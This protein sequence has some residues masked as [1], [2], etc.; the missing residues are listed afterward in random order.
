MIKFFGSLI[1]IISAV[2]CGLNKV[3]IE[4]LKFREIAAF[5][6]MIKYVSDNIEHY[7]KPLPEIF[8]DMNDEYLEK[9]GLLQEIRLNG[10]NNAISTYKFKLDDTEQ[11]IVKSF[12]ERIGTGYK[13]DELSLCRFTYGKLCESEVRMQQ[14]I[15]NTEKMYLTI[16]LLLALSVILILI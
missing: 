6:K 15:K 3:K 16:P 9:V 1:I 8:A 12:A 5:S 13:D 7:S 14:E 4:R 2:Y 11:K 10:I